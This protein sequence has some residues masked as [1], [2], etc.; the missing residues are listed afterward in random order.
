MVKKE[1]LFCTT[2]VLIGTL[3]WLTTIVGVVFFGATETNPLLANFTQINMLLFSTFKLSAITITGML[4]YKAGS[5]TKF[6]NEISPFAKKFLKS[7]Y[8]ISLFTLTAVVL[9]NFS[10]IA[11]LA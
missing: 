11:K 5:K 7:G 4:F 10:V 3:D 9:N 8:A 2:L 6:T 1:I